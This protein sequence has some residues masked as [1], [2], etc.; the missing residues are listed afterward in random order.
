MVDWIKM[1]KGILFAIVDVYLICDA[2]PK[3]QKELVGQMQFRM[4]NV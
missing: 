4:L 2:K 3:D 1:I